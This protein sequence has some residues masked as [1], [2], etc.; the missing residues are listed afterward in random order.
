MLG[1]GEG[2]ETSLAGG[3][4]FNVPAWAA[5]S[6]GNLRHF[7]FPLDLKKL[8]IFADRGEAGEA[9]S[10]ELFRRAINAGIPATV[11]L[12]K[13][14]DD[15]AEDLKQGYCAQDYQLKTLGDAP[16]QHQAQLV[17]LD[18]PVASN[19]MPQTVEKLL[20][21]AEALTR[22]GGVV[23]L[24]TI[25]ALVAKLAAADLGQLADEGVL[26]AIKRQTGV[27]IG[28]LRQALKDRRTEIAR[29]NRATAAWIS[30]C[31]TT[32]MG[33][34]LSNLANGLLA[35]RSDAAWHGVFSYDEM[36]RTAILCRP[37]PRFGPDLALPPPAFMERPV[38]DEDVTAAQEWL[39]RAGLVMIGKDVAH[40]AVDLV[41]RENSFHPVQEYLDSLAWDGVER[42]PTWLKVYF[43][44]GD[45]PYTRAIGQMFLISVV[46]R[47]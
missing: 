4:I 19:P 26:G 45:T 21:E 32:I 42:L 35:F 36:A 20:A 43:G 30:Q 24:D 6:A 16:P 28:K 13:S 11:L 12:P 3:K 14:D 46:A 10:N 5:L 47:I 23:A 27:G 17:V 7:K 29:Q 37:V 33:E 44:V 18:A 39:Q 38:R 1:I 2:I 34:P 25:Q 31:Q 8:F 22:D 15:F 40:S 9:A 41:S